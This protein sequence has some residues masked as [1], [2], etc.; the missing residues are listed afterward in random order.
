MFLENHWDTWTSNFMFDQNKG[1]LITVLPCQEF[2]LIYTISINQIVNY[3]LLALHIEE[4][5]PFRG[6]IIKA[7]CGLINVNC[8]RN[9]K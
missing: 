7:L 6:I 5:F 4:F 9:V 2:I 8:L 1:L 3:I